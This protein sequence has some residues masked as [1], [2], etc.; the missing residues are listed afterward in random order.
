VR[1]LPACL[2]SIVAAVVAPGGPLS[3]LSVTEQQA[4][5]RGLACSR[6]LAYENALLCARELSYRL[7]IR[8]YF[9]RFSVGYDENTTVSLGAPDTRGKAVTVSATQPILRGG[10]R[11][12]E[13]RAAQLDLAL[14]RGDLEERYR[15]LS[16]QVSGSFASILVTERKRGILVRTI[17]LARQNIDILAEQ[18]RLGGALELDLAQAELERLTLELSLTDTET[19]LEDARYQLKKL[20]SMDPEEPL[21]LVGGIERREAAADLSGLEEEL[22]AA[23]TAWSPSLKKQAAAV[24]K[25]SIQVAAASNPFIPDVDVELS[26]GFTGEQF[27]LRVPQYS[28]KLTFSFPIPESPT[29]TSSGASTTPGRD[30]GGS[31]SVKTSPL[32]SVSAWV[33]RKTAALALDAE[34][35]KKEEIGQDLRFQVTRLAGAY[36]QTGRAIELAR[37]KL[38]VQRRKEDILKRQ[39][40]VGEAKRIDYLQGAIET[41]ASEISLEQALLD[42]RE[43]ERSWESLLGLP[44][45]SF[46]AFVENERSPRR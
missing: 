37:R 15:A 3:A 10:T 5:E 11:P 23:A 4:V 35:R 31:L 38:E 13:R 18:V 41:A 43:A 42:L 27:P 32:E 7:G 36:A 24:Q 46:P 30:R 28:G 39:V 14:A 1:V 2:I 25:A 44:T 12:W 16:A 9:P 45:G 8:D 40:D 29:S 20:L 19:A 34:T 33:D 26:V 21:E 17:A 6:D 22:F